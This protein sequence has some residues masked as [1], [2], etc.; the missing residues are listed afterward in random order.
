MLFFVATYMPSK[1]AHFPKWSKN[2]KSIKRYVKKNYMDKKMKWGKWEELAE[3][4]PY[5]RL[6]VKAKIEKFMQPFIEIL[7]NDEQEK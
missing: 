2:L 7:W 4:Q 6:L 3:A 1:F 5:R